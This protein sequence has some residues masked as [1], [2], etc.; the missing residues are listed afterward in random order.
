M[1]A[2]HGPEDSA[3]LVVLAPGDSGRLEDTAPTLIADGLALAGIRVIR[4][5]AGS[6]DSNETE[7][8]DT[9]LADRVREASRNRQGSQK[10]VL[11][12]LSRGARVSASLV[13]ELSAHGLIGF[14]YPFHARGD[15]KPH[16][17]TQALSQLDVPVLICQGT[18]DSHG[19]RQQIRGYDLG[20]NIHVHW[21]ED[22]NHALHPR[23]R[24]G[25]NQREQ[26][27]AALQVVVAF[28]QSLP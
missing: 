10:L 28:I 13:D 2:T 20:E 5:A 11:A 12:G 24:S 22:A 14:A 16:G 19:N 3:H 25:T 21:L 27:K 8:Q 17:R 9:R 4:F 18:R 15:P 7:V 23:E 1:C 6:F 26:L